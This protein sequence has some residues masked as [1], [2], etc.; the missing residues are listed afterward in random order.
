MQ[1]SPSCSPATASPLLPT[2]RPSPDAIP[3]HGR[4]MPATRVAN[5]PT[6]APGWSSTVARTLGAE[7]FKPYDFF[8]SYPKPA[9]GDIDGNGTV[10]AADYAALKL[11]I[12]GRNVEAFVPE[13]A[14]LNGDGKVNAQDLV[15]LADMLNDGG[16]DL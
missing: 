12:V 4:S 14:D 16:L 1:A 3:S 6:T 15:L 11:Y 8:F 2:P 5:S 7:N 10:D 13:A 9:P